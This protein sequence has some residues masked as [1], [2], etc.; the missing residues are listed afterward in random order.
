MVIFFIFPFSNIQLTVCNLVVPL[1]SSALRYEKR[2]R[3]SREHTHWLLC[4]S[5][6]IEVDDT[7]TLLK[8]TVKP[9]SSNWDKALSAHLTCSLFLVHAVLFEPYVSR[10]HGFTPP[11]SAS[12]DGLKSANAERCMQH[13]PKHPV[14]SPR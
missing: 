1:K 7:Y 3:R 8:V 5:K 10:S 9:F 2:A 14:T 6:T 12:F 11:F 4:L 13:R